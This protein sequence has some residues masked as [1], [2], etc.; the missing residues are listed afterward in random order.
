MR[1]INAIFGAVWIV[2]V[3]A[4][5]LIGVLS[6]DGALVTGLIPFS[7]MVVDF[8]IERHYFKKLVRLGA[9]SPEKAVTREQAKIDPDPVGSGALKRLV[10]SGRVAVTED[11][12]YYAII[13]DKAQ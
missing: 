7:V 2:I 3:G 9:V 13:K 4:L 5:Y 8:F 1:I 11:N 6:P 10:K 12:R